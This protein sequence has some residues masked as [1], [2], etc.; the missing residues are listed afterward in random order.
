MNLEKWYEIRNKTAELSLRERVILLMV[1]IVL[2]LFIWAQFFYLQ[3]EKDIKKANQEITN[4]QQQEWS[5]KEELVNLSTRLSH[6]PNAALFEEQR[7]LTEK[8]D[9]L[10]EQ[11]E[12]RLSHLIAP[13]LMA[14]V[15]RKV[16]SDYKGLRLVKAKNLPVE[17]L[18]LEVNG[19][20]G[21][22]KD[23][24][25]EDAQAVIFSH[26]FEMVLNGDYFQALSFLMSLEKM[27]GFYWTLLKYEVE[28]YPKAKITLQLSTLS[29]DEDWIGV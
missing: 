15:M 29:L 26:R 8:L 9:G 21:S 13:E 18:K 11:I 10:K 6:D 1:G 20:K 23:T 12:I 2:V 3:F 25:K 17:P 4:L 28:E 19:D 14:D 5:Q 24:P 22:Q 27:D 7:K 16:L